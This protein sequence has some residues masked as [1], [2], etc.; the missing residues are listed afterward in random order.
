MIHRAVVSMA[1]YISPQGHPYPNS[2]GGYAAMYSLAPNLQAALTEAVS[3]KIRR[4]ITLR[5]I[6]DG[7]AAATVYPG[8]TVLV[9]GTA[10]G[11]GTHPAVPDPC[12][13]PA[14]VLDE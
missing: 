14:N 3:E 9:F 12:T 8:K 10:I 2:I 4:P 6:H 1:A 7:T 11:V 5:L 13:A